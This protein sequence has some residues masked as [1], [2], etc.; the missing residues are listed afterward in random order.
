MNFCL[1]FYDSLFDFGQ[2]GAAV[3]KHAEMGPSPA[4]PALP[5]HQL[6]S[7]LTNSFVFKF[8]QNSVIMS[9]FLNRIQHEIVESQPPAEFRKNVLGFESQLKRK[10]V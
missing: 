6:L 2:F 7:C 4:N 3:I 5:P 8:Q 10:F 1:F 9:W